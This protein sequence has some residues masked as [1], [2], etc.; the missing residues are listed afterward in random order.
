MGDFTYEYIYG[1][2]DTVYH[3]YI[4]SF[5]GYQDI[6]TGSVSGGAYIQIYIYIFIYIAKI[7]LWSQRRIYVR[8][9]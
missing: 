7:F 3:H 2:R 9:H 8:K 1:D 5:P 6:H 4:L